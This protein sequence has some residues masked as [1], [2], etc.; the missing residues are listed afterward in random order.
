[1]LS[2]VCRGKYGIVYACI[3]KETEKPC[4]IKVMQKMVNKRAD[5]MREADILKKITHPGV[6]RIF[7]FFECDKDYVLVTEM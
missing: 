4:A 7:D 1:M 3:S 2:L 6:L 5:V